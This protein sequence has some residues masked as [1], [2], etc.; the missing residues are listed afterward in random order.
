MWLG[1]LAQAGPLGRP[2]NPPMQTPAPHRSCRAV[3]PFRCRWGSPPSGVETVALSAFPGRCSPNTSP[4][5]HPWIPA[6]RTPRRWCRSSR[7]KTHVLRER[8]RCHCKRHTSQQRFHCS[9]CTCTCLFRV[10]LGSRL[11]VG[12]LKGRFGIKIQRAS[13]VCDA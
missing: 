3:D 6:C 7:G 1:V 2:M 13:R 11:F 4:G 8:C 5:P 9:G 12:P 10:G